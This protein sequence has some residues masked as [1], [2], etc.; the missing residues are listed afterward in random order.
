MPGLGIYHSGVVISG[1]EYTFGGGAGG[2]TG[3]VEHAPGAAY[4]RK[5][6]NWKF[7]KAVDLGRARLGSGQISSALS[8]LRRMFPS[9]SY[10]LTGKNCNHF[11]ELFCI[12]LGVTFPSWVN[13]AAKMANSMQGVPDFVAQQKALS[14]QQEK[15]RK[16]AEAEKKMLRE[17]QTKLKPEPAPGAPGVV[18]IQVNCPSGNKT[19]RRFLKTDTIGEVMEFVYAFDSTVKRTGFELLQTIPRKVYANVGQTLAEAGIAG[20]ANLYV[21][22]KL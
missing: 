14:A 3:V 2:G 20:R 4:G 10:H 7:Y 19:R 13:R 15:K 17:R 9:S 22:K 5:D 16:A 8:E 6:G 1:R 12:K 21:K 18:L 11:C